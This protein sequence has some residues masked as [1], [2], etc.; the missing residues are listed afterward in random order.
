M[1]LPQ[2]HASFHAPATVTAAG[3]ARQ[4]LLRPAAGDDPDVVLTGIMLEQLQKALPAGVFS[5]KT[6]G[7]DEM[8]TLP[9]SVLLSVLGRVGV[10]T[11]DALASSAL[12]RALPSPKV[13]TSLFFAVSRSGYSWTP[14]DH[15]DDLGEDLDKFMGS[16]KNL[17][18]F[19][20]T[21]ADTLV[22]E[23]PS[24]DAED[25]EDDDSLE[26]YCDFSKIFPMGKPLGKAWATWVRL[27][28][29]YRASAREDG[30]YH[31][32]VAITQEAFRQTFPPAAVQPQARVAEQAFQWLLAIP[33][34][35][36]LVDMGG[37]KVM[38]LLA[39]LEYASASEEG[40]EAVLFKHIDRALRKFPS[41]RQV[42]NSTPLAE[43][44]SLLGVVKDEI[45]NKKSSY[46]DLPMLTEADKVVRECL[47]A[48]ADSSSPVP[49]GALAIAAMVEEQKLVRKAVAEDKAVGSAASDA[50]AGSVGSIKAD[51]VKQLRAQRNFQDLMLHF[52]EL[53]SDPCVATSDFVGPALAS[54]L[55]DVIKQVL[56]RKANVAL[57]EVLVLAEPFC[58]P[59]FTAVH[60][61]PV[62]KFLATLLFDLV[63]DDDG[64]EQ[65]ADEHRNFE[66]AG[67]FL[68]NLL[69]G[70][71]LPAECDFE[72]ELIFK[73]DAQKHGASVPTKASREEMYTDP[74]L[75]RRLLLVLP[76]VFHKFLGYPTDDEFGIKWV[77]E[78]AITA[79]QKTRPI[80]A[81]KR[82][83]EA[84]VH[85]FVVDC[86]K[87]MG[88]ARAGWWGSRSLKAKPPARA[89]PSDCAALSDLT[90][91]VDFVME[92]VKRRQHLSLFYSEK[93]LHEGALVTRRG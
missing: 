87:A 4:R 54:N 86:L 79:L 7:D 10:P 77:L 29:P 44:P 73:V 38:L 84:A 39:V 5:Q 59:S 50:G 46:F 55:L 52:R 53:V 93:Q 15:A 89:L 40:R 35:F 56:G 26:M 74:D 72:M 17:A 18:D 1:P 76:D 2:G 27:G 49:S 31:N 62:S 85:K 67:Q 91:T 43:I 81:F 3:P 20:F 42:L 41:L 83:S 25:E 92:E 32:S 12:G 13:I 28:L 70:K 64:T 51:A 47:E 19:H 34:P 66:F 78:T 45:L 22:T 24:A 75:L 57:D 65:V 33:V 58:L 6:D 68:I 90:T 63:T 61:A 80:E 16:V 69:A 36:Y 60:M 88:R 71:W 82:D 14:F 30:D 37:S 23:S 9:W 8:F 48:F 11:G 21:V